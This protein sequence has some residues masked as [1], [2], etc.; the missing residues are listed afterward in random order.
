MQVFKKKSLMSP[1]IL[2]VPEELQSC[3]K[4]HL[5]GSLFFFV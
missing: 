5:T 2:S 4:V 3:K 1:N